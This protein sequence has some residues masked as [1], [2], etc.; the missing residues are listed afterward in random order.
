MRVDARNAMLVA[1][2]EYLD[3]VRTRGFWISIALLPLVLLAAALI[4]IALQATEQP[5][6]YTVVD[7]SGWVAAAARDRILE[8]DVT[9]VVDAVDGRDPDTL[10]PPLD[11]LAA[12][13]AGAMERRA[14]IT[15]WVNLLRLLDNESAKLREPTTLVERLADWWSSAPDAVA[16]VAPAASLARFRFQH[17]NGADRAMLN[18]LLDDEQ[19][20]GYFVIPEDPVADTVG[21]TYV[22]RKLTNPDL[23]RWYERIVTDVIR[24][25][26]IREENIDAAV[27]AWIQA[28]VEFTPI[29]L[30][31]TGAESR[32]GLVDTMAQWAP[33]AFV[34]V[35]WISIFAITQM[36]LTNTVEE[37]SNKL[38]EVLLSSISAIDLMAGKIVGIAATGLTIVATW[39]AM[40]IGV[41]MWLPL[42]LGVPLPFDL[43]GLVNN[44][45]YVTSFVVYFVLGY[46]FYAAIL[47][48]LGSLANNLKEAQ[49]LMM[50]VQLCLIVPLLIMVPIGRDPNGWLAATLSWLPPLTP[51]VMMNRAA[52][53]PGILTYVGT[54]LLMIA[55]IYLALRMAARVFATGIL[56][57]GKPPRLRQ[58]LTLLR[59][60]RHAR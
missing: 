6:R 54:T 21:A 60:R 22:T 24:D 32:A 8:R 58:L 56:M 23:R 13:L 9:A 53:P 1:S 49:N 5:A 16:D 52:F 31:A 48:A 37:K 34:Y 50:P 59:G 27:A 45:V 39:L 4:P 38:V 14:L 51:F 35:L 17:V 7:N 43:S 15:E 33:V 26:R 29:H 28:P 57:T 44:P 20:L 3:N 2:R 55:S 12:A 19:L 18:A 10:P 25:R 30:D 36:L 47:C 46:L 42:L 41:I 40:L 11:E